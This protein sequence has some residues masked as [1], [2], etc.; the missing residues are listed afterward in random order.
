MLAA[1]ITA[2]RSSERPAAPTPRDGGLMRVPQSDA[3]LVERARGG[4]DWAKEALY[5]RHLPPVWSMVLPLIGSTVEA[6]DIIQDAFIV[7]FGDI[8]KLRQ[9]DRFGPWLMRIAVRQVHRRFRRRRTWQSLGLTWGVEDASLDA[10]LCPGC[11]PEVAVELTK[12]AGVLAHMAP[13]NRIAWMLRFV[14]GCAL[15]EVAERTGVSLAT[16]KRR[17]AAADQRLKRHVKREGEPR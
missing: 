15:D 3:E 13:R 8:D 5:R 16:A 11:S 2:L 10:L 12:I 6:E 14:E 1:T 9:A 7:A 17:I 4:D